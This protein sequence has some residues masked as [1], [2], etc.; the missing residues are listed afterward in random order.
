[1]VTGPAQMSDEPEIRDCPLCESKLTLWRGWWVCGSNN[2]YHRV[3]YSVYPRE[4]R[5]DEH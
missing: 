2:P 3:P 1:M 4:E 5:P